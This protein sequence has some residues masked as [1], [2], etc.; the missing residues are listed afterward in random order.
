VAGNHLQ[1]GESDYFR[2]SFPG[3]SFPDAGLYPARVVNSECFTCPAGYDGFNNGKLGTVTV[4]NV[5]EPTSIALFLVGALMILLVRA[6][7]SR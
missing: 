4:A 3:Y 5:P 1:I 7:A 2:A 6:H